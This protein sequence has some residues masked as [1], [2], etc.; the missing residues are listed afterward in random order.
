MKPRSSHT[1]LQKCLLSTAAAGAL[2]LGAGQAQAFNGCKVLLCLA[3]NWQQ[4]SECVPDV[5]EALRCMARGRCWPTCNDAPGL[6]LSYTAPES[7][8]PQ[9]GLY[10]LDTCGRQVMVGCTK[11]AV[12]DIPMDGQ[13]GWARLWTNLGD[14]STP[15]MQYSDAAKL[16]MG[17]N[18]NP[19][20][21]LDYAAWVAMQPTE[22]PLTCLDNGGH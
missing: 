13:P 1:K 22:P 19:Q 4:I 14:G 11:N 5:K 3:G 16:F 6:S 20:F 7:C 12:I 15:V 10:E 18:A 8:P 21:D 2:L 9:Y 17:E